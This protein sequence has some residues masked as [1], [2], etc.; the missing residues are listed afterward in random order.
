MGTKKRN[1]ILIYFSILAMIAAGSTTACGQAALLLEEPYGFFGLLNP[2]GHNA[3]YFANICAET[4]TRLRRCQPGELGSVISRYG[5]VDG[6]DWLAIP[7]IPYLYS[8]EKAEE[9]PHRV[10]RADVRALREAYREIHFA[11]LGMSDRAGNLLRDGWDQLVGVSY[12]R[13]IFAFRFDTTREQDDALIARLNDSRNVT[14]F[15]LLYSNCSDY[16]RT[17]L[18]FYFPGGFHRSILSDAGITTPKQ[19][20][21][22]LVRWSRKHPEAKLDVF[23]IPQVPGYRRLSRRNKN[24]VESFTTTPYAIPMTLVNPY[25][26]ACVFVDYL[27]RGRVN[28]IP[29]NPR[30]LA[31]MELAVLTVP[32]VRNENAADAALQ[33]RSAAPSNP[34]ADPATQEAESGLKEGLEKHEQ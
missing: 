7:L 2:T 22:K 26:A 8:V 13:R 33:A 31:P 16:A 5:G 30:K 27:A 18:E 14:H 10:N 32:A 24:L 15:H 23:E 3:I 4:P 20:T 6:L 19:L 12:E 11:P 25:L 34:V 9:V 29:R 21:Y 28:L 17:I 1:F